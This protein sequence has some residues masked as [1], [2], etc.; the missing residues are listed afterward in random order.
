ME[1]VAPLIPI[2][3]NKGARYKVMKESMGPEA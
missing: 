1:D 2:Y 3:K